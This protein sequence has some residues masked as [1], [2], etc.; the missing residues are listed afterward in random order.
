[1]RKVFISYARSNK[2]D[3][4]Q[5]VEHLQTT[6]YEAWMDTSLRG[7]QR[8][9]DEILDNI[10][11]CDTFIAV[12]SEESLKST[13]CERELDW[14][15]SLSKPILPVL[16]QPL[17]ANTLPSRIALRH[18]ID[19]GEPTARDRVALQLA[20]ALN[21]MDPAPSLPKPLPAAPEAPTHELVAIIDLISKPEN[22]D[23]EQQREILRT[24]EPLAQSGD[25][26]TRRSVVG[27]LESLRSRPELYADVERSI[28]R[29]VTSPSRTR[30]SAEG[31]WVKL[32]G[33][34]DDDQA[35]RMFLIE[36][37]PNGV[38][39][40]RGMFSTEGSREPW[41]GRWRHSVDQ[42]G[43]EELVIEV[44]KWTGTLQRIND[45]LYRGTE[46]GP[47]WR[48]DVETDEIAVVHN[49]VV[50]RVNRLGLMIDR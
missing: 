23:H 50:V 44:D 11:G 14:A 1:M 2:H 10:A 37:L 34:L 30:S 41:R 5:L 27:V 42:N 38:V 29:L 48:D 32:V 21:T 47:I 3:V 22:L 36:T 25:S 43:E 39:T 7:G 35:G 4:D 18:F 40:E 24:V 19:Y 17:A 33:D 13:A 8:W 46:T 16:I 28:V 31:V 49:I 12:V 15:E 6:G 9:W 45:D 20:G 26:E